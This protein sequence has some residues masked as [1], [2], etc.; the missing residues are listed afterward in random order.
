MA[1]NTQIERIGEECVELNADESSLGKESTVLLDNAEEMRMCIA[2]REHHSLSAEGTYFRSANIERIAMVRQERQGNVGS[3]R[4]ESI[5]QT[6]A[7]DE[8]WQIIFLAHALNFHEF[9]S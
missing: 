3:I 8:K 7:I 1:S 4:C 5:T 9:R 2:M 6:S